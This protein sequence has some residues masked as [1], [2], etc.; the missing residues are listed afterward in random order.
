MLLVFFFDWWWCWVLRT[1]IN[2]VLLFPLIHTIATV[3]QSKGSISFIGVWISLGFMF[4]LKTSANIV[5][6]EF[7]LSCLEGWRLRLGLITSWPSWISLSP[8][9]DVSRF[10]STQPVTCFWSTRRLP[11]VIHSGPSMELLSV[12]PRKSA[13]SAACSQWLLIDIMNDTSFFFYKHFS[14]VR[15]IGP[16]TASSLFAI[17]IIHEKL[18]D[19]HMVFYLF[20]ILALCGFLSSLNI[21]AGG[22]QWRNS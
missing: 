17:S 2:V 3:E 19:G 13:G 8:P 22:E 5:F 20:A 18:L 1:H 9:S 7:K 6:C 11:H 14:F 21:R 15:A 12:A 4:L 10:W 16:I